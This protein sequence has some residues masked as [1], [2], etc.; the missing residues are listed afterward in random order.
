MKKLGIEFFDVRTGRMKPL[1]EQAEIL[2][3][4]LAGLSDKSKTEALKNIFGSDAAR[5]AIGLMEKGRQ[6][7]AD[8]QREIAGGDVGAK[9]DKRLEGE[10]AATTRLANAFESVKIAIGEAGLTDMIAR[11]KNGFAGFLESIAHAPPALL[12]VGVAVG[13]VA[14][15]LG[16]LAAG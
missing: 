2:R 6:G 9:I 16:P 12:K 1:A 7:I 15:A 8:L 4:A 5:T 11:V 13:A 10:A 3:K 14:A